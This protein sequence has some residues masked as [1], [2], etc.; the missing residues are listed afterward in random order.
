MDVLSP[1][2]TISMEK[3]V[4]YYY[5]VKPRLSYMDI[6][7]IIN[8]G[9][10]RVLSMRQLRA[11]CRTLSTRRTV[12]CDNDLIKLVSN[13]L[14]T[15]LSRVGY[16]QFTEMLN[17]K[18]DVNIAKDRVRRILKVVD[19]HGVNARRHR[20][21]KRRLYHC[22]GPFDVLHIDGNDKL[23]R[24]GFAIHGAM[25]GFSR[26]IM[27]LV[28]S[29]SNSDPLIIANLYL[30]MV[31]RTNNLCPNLVRMDRGNEN[32]YVEDLQTFFTSSDDSYLYA[33]S[34]RNQR[35]ESFWSRLKKFKLIWW[36][37]F[38]RQME[39]HKLFGSS[40]EIHQ[41][42]LIFC[43]IPVLQ[44]ELNVFKS[45]WNGRNIR[46]SAEAPGGILTTFSDV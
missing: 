26:K 2:I 6:L 29:V 10:H 8:F 16:R 40:S 20:T 38:F 9:H 35:I 18:Y 22:D 34:T 27:W 45:A 23:K 41:E 4:K 7:R 32:V 13:E 3:L 43:F 17:I 12:V 21:I 44:Y 31:V 33:A 14:S 37:D 46:K 5:Y 25:D 1:G 24:F 11:I 36:I 30:D 42:L 28:V 15:S 39:K 19:P